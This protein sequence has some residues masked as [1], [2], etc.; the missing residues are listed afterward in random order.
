MTSGKIVDTS[1]WIN[2]PNN[3]IDEQ[4]DLTDS[5]IKKDE[6]F[7]LPVIIQEVLQGIKE[8]N[9]FEL[10]KA[11]LLELPFSPHYDVEMAVSAASLY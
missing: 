7:I 2:Y 10:I 9:Q 5:F 6:I 1:V 8:E 4:T 3:I 11:A